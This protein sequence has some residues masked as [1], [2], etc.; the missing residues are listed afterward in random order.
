[1]TLN[2]AVDKMRGA[3]GTPVTLEDRPRQGQGR[4]PMDVKLN[5]AVITIKSVRNKFEQKDDVGYIRITQ[6]QRADPSMA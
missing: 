2:Q 5:R 6:F 1:M 4:H 3:V